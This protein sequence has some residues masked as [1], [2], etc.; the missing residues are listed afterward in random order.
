MV[1]NN[2]NEEIFQDY[3]PELFG[4]AYRMLGSA[5]EAEDVLQ[6]AY[7]RHVTSSPGELRSPRAYFR[8]IVTRLCLDRLKAART[9]REQ[10]IGPWLPEPLLTVD[11]TDIL[12]AAE[13]HESITMAFLVLLERLTPQERAVFLLHDVFDYEHAEIAQILGLSV[14]N[15]RQILRRAKE[16]IAE[17][18]ARFHPSP[19]HQREMVERF[20]AAVQTGDLEPLT[21]MLAREVAFTSDGGG[22]A[23]AARKPLLGIPAVMRMLRSIW[24][25]AQEFERESS[26]SARGVIVDVNGEPALLAWVGDR[27]ETVFLFGINEGKIESIWAIRNPDKLAYIQDQFFKRSRN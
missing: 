20:S 17:G 24:L 21:G 19:R 2:P 9:T 15:S 27:L 6:D 18:R 8:T 7:L 23:A 4:I 12:Q 26:G 5:S 14:A 11:D 1:P 22:K 16:R 13:M 3:R 25:N 10:Y